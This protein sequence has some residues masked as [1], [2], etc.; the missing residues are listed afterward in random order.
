MLFD[1]RPYIQLLVN[2]ILRLIEGGTEEHEE[3][4]KFKH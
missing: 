1:I 3:V 4:M 2:L